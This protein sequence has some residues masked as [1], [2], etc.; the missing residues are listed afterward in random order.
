MKQIEIWLIIL[1]RKLLKRG[2]FRSLD[3][4]KEQILVF[5]A[6]YNRTMAKLSSGRIKEILS[7]L[8]LIRKP[9]VLGA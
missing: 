2:N 7:Y 6:Y 9:N 1:V 5:I 4:L 3:A 8:V